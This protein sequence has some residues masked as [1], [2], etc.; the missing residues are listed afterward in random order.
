ADELQSSTTARPAADKNAVKAKE[1]AKAAE[2]G[3]LKA[4]EKGMLKERAEAKAAEKGMVKATDEAKA[5]VEEA[6]HGQGGSEAAAEQ[7]HK[8]LWVEPSGSSGPDAAWM[9]PL[10]AREVLK[11]AEAQT[12]GPEGLVWGLETD[13][14][15]PPSDARGAQP[16]WQCLPDL[17]NQLRRASEAGM[18]C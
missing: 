1:E 18:A 11:L 12:L 5:V 17:G 2:K 14:V 15:G 6:G 10:S 3:G 16:L 4:A 13:A 8:T 9:G 7:G